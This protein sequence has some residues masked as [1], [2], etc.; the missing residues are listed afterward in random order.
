MFTAR[1][2]NCLDPS[3][4][5]SGLASGFRFPY[6]GLAHHITRLLA[7]ASVPHSTR[8]P[9]V[10]VPPR[11]NH[12]RI[13]TPCEFIAF[14]IVYVDL[15]MARWTVPDQ[16]CGGRLHAVSLAHFHERGVEDHIL[17]WLLYQAHVEHWLPACGGGGQ[18]HAV[19][20]ANSVLL[21]AS[22]SFSLTERGESFADVFL[23][24]ALV[25]PDEEDFDRA[26]DRLLLGQV[27]PHYDKE[28]RIFRW[29]GHVLKCFRQ[30]AGNQEL[31]LAAAEELA[32]LAWM[33][34]PL[35][36]LPGVVSK[37]RL[38][39]TIKDLNRRQTPPLI[40]FKGDGTGTRIGWEYR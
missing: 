22:S 12:L 29:G 5:V 37:V 3:P 38:H 1:G 18:G 6:Q 30:P 2:E 13:A 25:P 19:A 14:V 17:L 11:G 21:G 32:W 9:A 4:V 10:S 34:D 24:E 8:L 28:N 40:H 7:C 16:P 33:D 27:V 23:A 35:P 36:K 31:I 39:D 26:Q 20:P 15:L